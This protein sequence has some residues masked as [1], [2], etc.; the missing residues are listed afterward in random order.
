[1]ASVPTVR[2]CWI[3]VAACPDLCGDPAAGPEALVRARE[4]VDHVREGLRRHNGENRGSAMRIERVLLMAAP[5]SIDDEVTDKGH[6][7]QR[8]TLETRAELVE[9]L[10]REPLSKEVLVI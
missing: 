4:V 10:Y 1:M 5:P 3:D 2:S 8:A 6:I 9:R 7:N